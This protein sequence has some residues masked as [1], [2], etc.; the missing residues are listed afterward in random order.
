MTKEVEFLENW[1][2]EYR[3]RNQYSSRGEAID[4]F[5]EIQARGM[6]MRPKDYKNANTI[7]DLWVA[8]K[9]DKNSI[10]RMEMLMETLSP[11]EKQSI[12][13]WLMKI[14]PHQERWQGLSKHISTSH[15]LDDFMK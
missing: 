1:I 7:L 11:K 5:K 4:A 12:N 14:I 15:N 2:D 9:W 13:E 10:E 8:G 3:N 6:N